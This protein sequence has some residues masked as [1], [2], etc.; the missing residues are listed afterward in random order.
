MVLANTLGAGPST[1][2]EGFDTAINIGV[3]AARRT[4]EHRGVISMLCDRRRLNGPRVGNQYREPQLSQLE[5][6]N[7]QDDVENY[8]PQQLG[9]VDTLIIDVNSVSIQVMLS[10]DL[11]QRLAPQVWMQF[12]AQWTDA[13]TRK[14]DQDGSR[15]LEGAGQS[16]GA[17]GATFDWKDIR[18]AAAFQRA[19][20]TEPAMGMISCV[21][22]GYQIVDVASDFTNQASGQAAFGEVTSGFTQQIIRNG[23]RGLIHDTNVHEDNLIP[24]DANDDAYAFVFPREGL[25]LVDD[26]IMEREMDRRPTWGQGAELMILRKKYGYGLRRKSYF[27][28]RIH[29]DCARPMD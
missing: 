21:A 6:F 19:N 2:R 22:H 4:S 24:I 11:R 18:N 5:A 13:M 26:T 12:G 7:I 9:I 17:A 15:V 14:L 25:V 23:F 8:N 28:A 3:S 27:S 1:P 20:P 10:D 16:Y 29:S